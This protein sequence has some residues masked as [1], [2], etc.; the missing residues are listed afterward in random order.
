MCM[1]VIVEFN[2]QRS[3]LKKVHSYGFKT[4]VTCP[5]ENNFPRNGVFCMYIPNVQCFRTRSISYHVV[6]RDNEFA[7]KEVDGN[8]MV[9]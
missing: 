8:L 2:G 5:S 3:R 6:F 7:R 4:W 9:I 1:Q